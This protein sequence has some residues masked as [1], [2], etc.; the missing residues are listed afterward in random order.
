MTFTVENEL[1]PPPGMEPTVSVVIDT[2][3]EFDWAA[4]FS[5]HATSVDN[6]D[7]QPLAQRIFDRYG[8]VPTYVID[9][10]VAMSEAARAVL[11]PIFHQG[12]CEI[13]AH[14]HPW[15]NPPHEETINARHSFPGNLP[16]DAERHKLAVLTEAI[17]RGFGQAPQVYKAGRY[18]VGPQTDRILAEIGYT[19][20]V[21]VVPYTD[22]SDRSGPD[23]TKFS[24]RPFQTPNGV[25][26]IPL[27]VDFC[28]GLARLGRLVY[29]LLTGHLGM[30]LRLPGIA[31]RIGLMERIRLSP[32]GHSLDEMIRLTRSAL[33][34]GNPF[35]MLTYHSSS[36]LPRATRYVQTKEDRQA[37]LDT[38][39]R[40][41]SFFFETCGGSTDTVRNF[42]SRLAKTSQSLDKNS[43]RPLPN[44]R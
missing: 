8:I 6:I 34:R 24:P 40:F 30:R 44:P 27:S 5:P 25:T 32:E 26:V 28:G 9:Y 19:V 14:L 42:A 23:F 35:F 36:L 13:G 33:A 7:C 12:R 39:D 43:K 15:V 16:A 20:D 10:P 17:A 3:E 21:S 38:L 18:G 37:F 11:R 22:F 31:G 29:P 41:F 2:E 4:P 1:V